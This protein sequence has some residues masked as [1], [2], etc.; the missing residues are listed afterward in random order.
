MADKR[1]NI[2]LRFGIVYFIIVIAFVLVILQIVKIQF[3][4]RDNWLAL[5]RTGERTDIVVKPKRGNIYACDG[6]LMAS[7]IP[8]YRIYMDTQV[9]SLRKKNGKKDESLFYENVD[10]ISLSLSRLFKDKSPNE[11]KLALSNAYKRGERRF[12]V[13]PHRISYSQLKEVQSFP[14][15]RLGRNK[16]GLYSEEYVQRVKPFGSLASRTIGDVY[17]EE[18]KGG[19]SGLEQSYNTVLTGK[20]GFATRRKVANTWQETIQLEPVDGMDIVTTIDVDIQDISENALLDVLKKYNAK[21]G[22][23][24][25]M[26]TK[27]GEVKSIVNMYRSESGH[28]YEKENGAVSDMME[29]GSTFKTMILMALLDEGKVNLENIVDVGNGKLKYHSDVPE[30]T[31]HNADKGGYGKISIANVLHGSSN[32]GMHKIAY[33]AYGKNQRELVDKLRNMNLT[34]PIQLE[35]IG[36]GTPHIKHPQE[37]KDWSSVTSLSALSRGYEIKMPPIYTL[38]HYNAIANNGRMIKPLFVKSV[39]KDGQIIKSYKTETIN[40]SICKNSTLNEIREMLLGVVEGEIGTAKPAHSDVVRIAG[41][42]GTARVTNEYGKYTNRHRVSFCGYFPAENPLYT[43]IVVITEPSVASAG[44]TCG[45][46]FKNIAE[47]TM[48][49][50]SDVKPQK[51][52]ADS[53]QMENII[54]LPKIKSG[55]YEALQMIAKNMKLN[56][57]GE[58]D[59]WVKTSVS[60]NRI[61]TESIEFSDERIPDVRGMGARDAVYLLEKLELAVQIQGRGKVVSQS[62][63]PGTN[64]TKGRIIVLNLR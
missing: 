14:L 6:R 47:R 56:M 64:V 41:K 36:A 10:S 61:R 4:E 40:T 46:V 62:I 16:S 38:T 60:E 43:G 45:V 24:I 3:K 31:D 53:A 19:R 63:A 57:S 42:T 27:T 13:Y 34:T 59:E 2:I 30:V 32:V 9:E 54:V 49:L 35:I 58:S 55:N 23:A 51:M 1:T 37:D 33:N 12:S 25:V 8:T 22:Y 15:F 48:A 52:A 5:M 50:K 29:P 28:Y 20:S 11:Y 44:W 18:T 26:E 17:A 21:S 7:S 39:S